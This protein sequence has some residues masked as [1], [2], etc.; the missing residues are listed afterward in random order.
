MLGLYNRIAFSFVREDARLNIIRRPAVAGK[1]YPQDPHQLEQEI[2][3]LLAAVPVVACLPKILIVPHAG[4]QYSGPVAAT[5]FATLNPLRGTIQR[6]VVLGTCHSRR[7]PLIFT[8]NADEFETPLGG[9]KTNINSIELA[10]SHQLAVLDDEAHRFDHAIEVQLP[11]LQVQLDSFE[12][13]PF[14]VAT[15]PIEQVANLINLLWGGTET[16]FVISS[17]LSHYHPY[18]EA[19]ELDQQT[20]ESIVQ[21]DDRALNEQRACGFYAI[22]GALQVAR[23]KSLQVLKLDL[24]ISGDTGGPHDRVVGYGAFAFCQTD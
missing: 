15:S 2:R 24:R 23:Q 5:G 17:D 4:Y 13:V 7:E 11:F 10:L 12:L 8:S 9:I 6:V 22:A 16:L 19:L 1:F 21:L 3:Q 14:L 18:S 20:A